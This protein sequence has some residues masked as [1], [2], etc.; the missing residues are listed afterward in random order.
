MGQ[1][2][3]ALGYGSRMAAGPDAGA[4]E[5]A[6]VRDSALP[7]FLTRFVTPEAVYGLVLFAAI[8]AAVSDES[9]D[10]GADG[11][12]I[13]LNDATYP[14]N[15]EARRR[16]HVAATRA[17]WQLWLVSGGIRSKILPPMEA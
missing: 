4:P 9:D 8:V 6:E 17:V 16:L 14:V 11:G 3:A 5:I 13:V 2:E 12:T 7:H 15:D 1:R 10:P